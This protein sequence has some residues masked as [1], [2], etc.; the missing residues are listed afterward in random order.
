[1]PQRHRTIYLD[2][3]SSTPVLPEV[4]EAMRPWFS[5]SFGSASSQHRLGIE[6]RDAIDRARSQAARLIHAEPGDDLI[7]TSGATESANLAIKGAAFAL[8]ARRGRIVV[9]AVEHPAVLGAARFLE[10]LGFECVRVSCDRQGFVDPAAVGR[11]LTDDT[12]LVAVQHAN[13]EIGAL[14]PI[15]Q[16]AA[17]T[18][19]RGIP[20]F[21]DASA[22]GGWEPIDAPQLGA[23]LVSLSPHRFH[24]PKGAGI[25]YRSRRARLESLIHG[26][27]QEFN[28]RAGTENIPAVVGAGAACEIAGR[29]LAGERLR[30]GR[31]QI[32]LIEGLAK[33]ISQS[34]LNGPPP[35]PGRLCTNVNLS[36]EGIDGESLVLMADL[37]GIALTS[38]PSCV[39]RNMKVSHVLEAIGL[40]EELARGNTLMSLG[41]GTAGADIHFVLETLPELVEK[42]RG[43][44][45]GWRKPD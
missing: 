30:I 11:L 28:L 6:A 19:A 42:L 34:R 13:A 16:I 17:I 39:T 22:S 21:C 7:F 5:D 4:F 26:G 37:K 2:H 18:R 1:M 9:S 44:S 32:Q 40:P 10:G 25:L 33:S 27:K 38:G 8:G 20:L 23:E 35:G 31:L 15:A 29:N 3:H 12:V 41:R 24:G 43:M 36:F 45:P 14:Q